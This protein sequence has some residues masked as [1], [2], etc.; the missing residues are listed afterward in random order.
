MAA[1]TVTPVS[2]LERTPTY[3]EKKRDPARRR[4]PRPADLPGPPGCRHRHLQGVA[5][6][7][8]A[9]TRRRISSCPARSFARSTTATARRSPSRGR[10]HP[11]ARRPRHRRRQEDVEV[12]RQHDRHPRRAG[13]DP[14]AGH[15]D[16]HRHQRILRT[17]PGRPEI[18]NVCQLHRFFG[19]DYEEIWD[20]ERTAR[21]G[22]VDTKKLLAER[23]VR[24]YAPARERY[25]ELMAHPDEVDGILEAGAR[26]ARAR[27]PR[28][29][30]PRSASGW[31]CASTPWRRRDAVGSARIV[32]YDR[33]AIVS[34]LRRSPAARNRRR[35]SRCRLTLAGLYT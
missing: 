25:A 26:P 35:I 23:I 11:G 16:G 33:D 7:G 19:D 24:H 18:C 29:R 17:D 32:S 4:Q 34:T 22:C 13:P 3:K 2:W 31:G 8:R 1:R 14:E 27:R 15:V 20:G 5:G 9:R 28:R 21:T 12:A 30:W 6:P 10:V